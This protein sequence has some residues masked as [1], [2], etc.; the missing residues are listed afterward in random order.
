[1]ID[2]LEWVYIIVISLLAIVGALLIGYTRFP[3]YK[4]RLLRQVTGRNYGVVVLRGRGGH[5]VFKMHD[6]NVVTY[7]YGPKD[8]QK[9][10]LI[11]QENLDRFGSVPVIY[12][13]IDDV[14]PITFNTTSDKRMAP[15]NLN[16]IFMLLK[17]WV[18]S[19]AAIVQNKLFLL[20]CATV[21]L[22]IIA[23]VLE[24]NTGNTCGGANGKLD[25]LLSQQHVL[26]PSPTPFSLR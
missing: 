21:I 16:S 14:N 12:F 3:A 23:L 6:F 13:N 9:T 11:K 2:L 1:M 18:E 8:A 19:G 24:Y 25:L 5:L 15:E 10:Y 17:A 7:S 26:I 20:A 4:A 22:L